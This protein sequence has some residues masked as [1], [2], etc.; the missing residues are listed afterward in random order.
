MHL[1][2]III[3]LLSEKILTNLFLIASG[4]MRIPT[5]AA[6]DSRKDNFW[7]SLTPSEFFLSWQILSG[8][9]TCMYLGGHTSNTAPTPFRNTCDPPPAASGYTARAA[10][11]VPA[12]HLG[13]G[14]S[15]AFS[16]ANILLIHQPI[17]IFIVIRQKTQ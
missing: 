1:Y 9:I 13:I 5:K 12:R 17:N 15:P 10:A 16:I 8:Y 11:G 14:R 4:S 2:S 3:P 6:M 7:T